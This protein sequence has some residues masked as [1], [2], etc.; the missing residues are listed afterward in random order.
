[1]LGHA[2]R[3]AFICAALLIPGTTLADSPESPEAAESEKIREVAI[4][5]QIHVSAKVVAIDRESRVVTIEGEGGTQIPIEAPAEAANFDQVAVGDEV[6]LSYYESVAL[7]IV[8]AE[9]GAPSAVELKAV[10]LAPKGGTPGGVIVDTVRRTA[11]VRAVD[12]GRR[13]VT[14]DLPSGY[15]MTLPVDKSVDLLKVK[16]GTKVV[17][18]YTEAVAITLTRPEKPEFSDS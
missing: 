2:L 8:P 9:G 18:T 14:L 7:A 11:V 1:M 10:A 6:S 3:S 4:G 16:I 12:Q 5:E 17:A 13:T 15:L